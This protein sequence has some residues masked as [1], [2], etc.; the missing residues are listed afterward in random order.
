MN[1]AKPQGK[2]CPICG[3]KLDIN[4]YVPEISEPGIAPKAPIDPMQD[5]VTFCFKCRTVLVFNESL[6]VVIPDDY[7]LYE[8]T[9]SPEF[10]H[11]VETIDTARAS[12]PNLN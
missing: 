6:N 5:D 10:R 11:F 9:H 7:K 2:L 1:K 12:K 8:I 4:T 3:E